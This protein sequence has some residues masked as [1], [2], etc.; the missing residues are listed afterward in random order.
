V[1]TAAAE[2]RGEKVTYLASPIIVGATGTEPAPTAVGISKEFTYQNPM[3]TIEDLE[4]L[5]AQL[6]K[7]DGI[8]AVSGSERT[9]TIK[10]DPAKLD[11]TKVRAIMTELGRAVR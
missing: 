4:P 5:E 1:N 10:W 2:M 11:E 6:K 8:L 3:A 9:I 7:R